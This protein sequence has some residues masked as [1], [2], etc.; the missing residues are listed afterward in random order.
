MA[1]TPSNG[2]APDGQHTNAN[3]TPAPP[4]PVMP[5]VAAPKGVRAARAFDGSPL[6]AEEPE[7]TAFD[8]ALEDDET[9]TQ[10]TEDAPATYSETDYRSDLQDTFLDSI[11]GDAARNGAPPLGI[12]IEKTD[13][14]DDDDELG[15]DE[16]GTDETSGFDAYAPAGYD[17]DDDPDPYGNNEPD[18][19]AAGIDALAT[20]EGE[21]LFAD[22]GAG[23]DDG[24]ITS[25]G[26]GDGGDGPTD[27]A[28]STGGSG[29][30]DT[31]KDQELGL[32]EHLSELRSRIIYAVLGVM[33]VMCITWNYAL[34]IQGWFSAPI[35]RVLNSNGVFK[36]ELISTDPTAFFTLQFQS[37]LLAALIIAAPWVSFQV[38]R[39]IEPALTNSERRYTLVLVPFSSVLFFM[40]A[41][42]GYFCAPLFFQFFLQ[43]QPP[44]VAAQWKYDESVILMA[45]MLL[46]FGLAFQVPIVI[47]F[48]HKIGLIS[49]NLLIEYWRHAV[50]AIFIV[51][52]VLTPTWDPFTMTACALPPC[53]LYLLSIWLVKWL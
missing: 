12:S 53:L 52:A 41:A 35:N 46:I 29:R 38:W 22:D 44:G 7:T 43:F 31:P 14:S 20:I 8:Q 24:T 28:L 25:A 10:A 33:L 23:G 15:T 4:V 17:E 19:E 50:V 3:G 26:G 27:T 42:L 16:L 39:F 18:L 40:G 45:K 47:I 36:G 21:Q 9:E 2:H 51:V 34:P 5:R 37:S 6:P 49:R 48:G 11:N 32:F 1:E 30:P 13:E